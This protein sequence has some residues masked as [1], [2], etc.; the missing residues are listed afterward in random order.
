MGSAR[1]EDNC[2]GE[3]SKTQA[4]TEFAIRGLK[5]SEDKDVEFDIL[6]LAITQGKTTIQPC[7][8]CISTAGGAHCHYPCD[9]YGKNS[10]SRPDKMSDEDVYQR[11][12]LADA[13]IVFSPIYWYSLTSQVKALFDR[14]VCI[15]GTITHDEAKKLFGNNLK[16]AEYTKDF[17]HTVDYKKMQKNHYSGKIGAFF[18]QGDNGADDY[19]EFDRTE[20]M[21]YARSIPDTFKELK[22]WFDPK[23]AAMPF[24][25][26]C[27]YSD[28][29][30]PDEFIIA[31]YINQ[32]ISYAD[33]DIPN[34]MYASARQLV[35]NVIKKIEN[36][37]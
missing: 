13:F 27:R 19:K 5:T 24:V 37:K 18:I 16:N 6:D 26:Q 25:M 7:K 1:N 35:Q 21:P 33:A 11:F 10:T 22:E 20:L 12:E 30:V 8:G 3:S 31:N 15:N 4:I 9:C 2:P 23:M 14:L 32:G 28:I 34:T 36:K 17:A 29:D